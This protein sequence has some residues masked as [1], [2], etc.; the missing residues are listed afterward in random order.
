MV[1]VLHRCDN[2]LCV[3]PNH[4]FL[5]NNQDNVDDKVSK[6]RQ[7]K[8]SGTKNGRHKVNDSQIIEIRKLYG[9]KSHTQSDL[10]KLYNISI[11]QI[12]KIVNNK[13]WSQI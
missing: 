8:P 3:N 12:S 6:N 9:L 13:A 2:R 1:C 5:G 7:H 4:L 11:I 10:S